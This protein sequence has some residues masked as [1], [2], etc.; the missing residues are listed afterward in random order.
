MPKY[1][2]F[3][4]NQPIV[5]QKNANQLIEEV[6]VYFNSYLQQLNIYATT[7]SAL[8][9]PVAKILDQARVKSLDPEYLKGYGINTHKNSVN[10]PLSSEALMPLEEGITLLSQLLQKVPRHLRP[11]VIEIISYK[12]YYKREKANVEFWESWRNAFEDFLTKKYSDIQ[13][14]I[15]ACKLDGATKKREIKTFQDIVQLPKRL[16]TPEL[17][18]VVNE[19]T[20][21]RKEIILEEEVE[22]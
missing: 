16:R 5:E 20:K 12:L 13:T 11:K 1:E 8:M 7:K 2:K 22:E 6:S 3:D 10:L 9:G 14:L 19:F 21:S 4:L 17:Q 18:I 15:K